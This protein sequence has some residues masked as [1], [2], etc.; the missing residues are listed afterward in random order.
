MSVHMEKMYA[1]KLFRRWNTAVISHQHATNQM[2]HYLSY[3]RQITFITISLC[4]I[5]QYT[6]LF[7][8]SNVCS[9]FRFI[10]H[11]NLLSITTYFAASSW[12]RAY[13]AS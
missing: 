6:A 12:I 13:A 7:F 11:D 8:T 1:R 2:L 10:E 5:W 3:E 4:C 9:P